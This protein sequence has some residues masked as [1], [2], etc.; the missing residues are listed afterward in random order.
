MNPS[1]TCM[2]MTV[3]SRSTN[4][5]VSLHRVKSALFHTMRQLFK[6]GTLSHDDRDLDEHVRWRHTFVLVWSVAMI[7]HI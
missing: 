4:N 3:V 2:F 6:E 1:L 5:F 7:I